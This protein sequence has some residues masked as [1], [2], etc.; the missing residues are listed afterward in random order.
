MNKIAIIIL[1]FLIISCR[2][3]DVLPEINACLDYDQKTYLIGDTIHFSS[4]SENSNKHQWDF[5]D[6]NSS[7]IANPIH[8]FTKPGE[9]VIE[10]YSY[11][12]NNEMDTSIDTIEINQLKLENVVISPNQDTVNI[13]FYFGYTDIGYLYSFEN[14]DIRADNTLYYNSSDHILMRYS[15][16]QFWYYEV[17]DCN[18]YST[19]INWES[20]SAY[21]MVDKNELSYTIKNDSLNFS[22]ILNFT[23]S[24]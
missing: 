12:S 2:K 4:C 20:K 8:I 13:R 21:E 16:L 1:T 7:S 9:Y 15:N 19:S 3:K 14:F 22:I 11:N 24:L 18:F 5:G 10:H 17:D 23:T 6:G